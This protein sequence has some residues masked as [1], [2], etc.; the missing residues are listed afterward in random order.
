MISTLP[1]EYRIRRSKRASN[2]RIVV[3]PG[4]VE[5][6]A[7]WQIPDY[8]L[9]KFVQAKQEWVTQA[10]N[11][12]AA[13]ASQRVFTP[14][15]FKAGARISYRGKDYTLTVS[16]A[17]LKRTKIEFNGGYRAYVPETLTPDQHHRH[18]QA[19]LVQWMKKQTEAIA[20]ELAEQH[21]G[22]H[23][24]KPRSISVRTQRSRWGS[25]GI[26]NDVFINWLLIMA[27]EDVMEYVVVHELCHIKEKNHSERFWALVG[28]HL[29]DY[30]TRRHWLKENGRSLML[31][32]SG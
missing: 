4:Q 18:I 19:A 24:L 2:A 9:H 23:Q 30:K 10:L 15:E 3:K 21:A 26:H 13:N 8:K 25:C 12:M 7:P 6:V 1:F 17:K 22:K 16:P 20:H 32:F 11:K 14:G 27:P 5:V 29:P 28:D 31:A